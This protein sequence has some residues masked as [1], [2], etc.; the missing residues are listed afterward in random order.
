MAVPAQAKSYSE[1]ELKARFPQRP[2]PDYPQWAR[3]RHLAGSGVFRAR[4]DEQGRVTQ[5]TILKSTGHKELDSLAVQTL[6]RWHG[7]PG[8]KWDLN[9]PITFTMDMS[10]HPKNPEDAKTYR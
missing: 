7:R 10:I 2:F 9:I 8:P 5:I 3:A 1:A 6:S 4:V